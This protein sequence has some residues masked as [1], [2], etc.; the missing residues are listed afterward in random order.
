MARSWRGQLGGG[1]CVRV[2]VYTFLCVRQG[3]GGGVVLHPKFHNI[4]SIGSTIYTTKAG[5]FT[6]SHLNSGTVF[7]GHVRE[8][9]DAKVL[10]KWGNR[11]MT[12]DVEGKFQF[13]CCWLCSFRTPRLVQ[14]AQKLNKS[15]SICL[16][17]GSFARG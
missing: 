17:Y 16:P 10:W 2:C 7:N 4:C 3:V 13:F 1:L 9:V 8:H 12:L 15:D 14:K 5:V 11:I 6:G